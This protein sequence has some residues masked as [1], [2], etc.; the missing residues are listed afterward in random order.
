VQS[1][2]RPCLSA[3]SPTS[4][5]SES[6]AIRIQVCQGM[7]CP[8]RFL[9]PPDRMETADSEVVAEAAESAAARTG[10]RAVADGA[11]AGRSEAAAEAAGAPV[12]A[13]TGD[14]GSAES[15]ATPSGATVGALAAAMGTCRIPLCRTVSLPI[16][17][18][19]SRLVVRVSR[20]LLPLDLL[21]IDPI[22]CCQG[23]DRTRAHDSK[24]TRERLSPY[25]VWEAARGE[26]RTYHASRAVGVQIRF[27]WIEIA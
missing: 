3:A 7:D 11:A 17:S 13:G 27:R 19:G 9:Q 24:Q 10:W 6:S 21:G 23:P 15:A 4:P 14:S 2:R 25:G 5:D 20:M 1:G 18:A 22:R 16:H 8:R 26:Q 12:A